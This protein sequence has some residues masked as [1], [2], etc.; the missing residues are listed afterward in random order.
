LWLPGEAVY[1]GN[2]VEIGRWEDDRICSVQSYPIFYMVSGGWANAPLDP[3]K[4]P[5]E[6]VVDYIRVWQ[7]ADL[8]S[9]EDGP[10]PNDGAPRSQF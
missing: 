2:G 10:K 4:L 6:F 5:D 1:Y 8:A 9:P 3:S 7:R